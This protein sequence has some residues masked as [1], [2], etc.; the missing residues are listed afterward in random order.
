[1]RQ[2][3]QFLLDGIADAIK[4]STAFVVT[5]YQKISAN[6]TAKFRTELVKLGASFMGVKKRVFA[7]AAQECGI[8]INSDILEGHIGLAFFGANVVDP[9]K[10]VFE[11]REQNEEVFKILGGYFDHKVV[12]AQDV[13]AISKLPTQDVMRAQLLGLLQMPMAEVLGVVEALLTAVPCCLDN[14]AQKES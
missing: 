5:S 10:K 6:N 11:F 2:E 7:K 12:S 4:G 8:T 3:K 13:E 9:T 1:M 14:K